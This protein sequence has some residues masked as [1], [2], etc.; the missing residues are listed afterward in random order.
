MSWKIVPINRIAHLIP[1]Q[2]HGTAST[3]FPI[4]NISTLDPNIVASF[5]H[6][7]GGFATFRWDRGAI[8]RGA[9]NCCAFI[10]HNLGTKNMTW[11]L[12]EDNVAGGTART[13]ATGS[14]STNADI[15]SATSAAGEHLQHLTL[16][17]DCDAAGVLT[18][19]RIGTFIIGYS[20][21]LGGHPL[22]SG[23]TGIYSN[24]GE[25]ANSM[26]GVPQFSGYSEGGLTVQRDFPKVTHTDAVAT[27]KAMARQWLVTSDDQT[28][29][30][31]GG[32]GG[33]N[34]VV[35]V[36]DDGAVMYGPAT[37][38]TTQRAPALDQ[39]SL[40]IQTIPYWGLN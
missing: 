19:V 11:T 15:Y 7:D 24:S 16:N 10:N 8:T 38:N 5:G 27:A 25:M 12:Y 30:G 4:F 29:D 1:T 20:Y 9:V 3:D 18:G 22:G 23:S 32:G 33:R 39:L 40:S 21:D 26:I 36:D 14:P 37:V 35:V 31:V 34:P 28:I 13:L 6:A 17:I 2:A